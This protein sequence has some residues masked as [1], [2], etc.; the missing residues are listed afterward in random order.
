MYKKIKQTLKSVIPEAFL[1][2][3]EVILRRFHSFLYIGNKHQCI[4]CLKKTRAF[5]PIE[6][7]DLLCPSC[8]SRSRTRRLWQ[9]LNQNSHING[10]IL[11]FSPSRSIYRKLIKNKKIN[12]FSSDFEGEFLADYKFDITNIQQEDNKFDII[13]CY[14]ILEHIIEDTK[15]MNELYRVLKPNGTIYIQTPYKPGN[16]YENYSVTSPEKREIHFGQKDHVRIY[17]I[18]GLK[19]RL[20]NVGFTLVEKT[21]NKNEEDSFFGFISPETFIMATKE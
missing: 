15:A 17:S 12:Y 20:K 2:N 13:I 1:I 18:N 7:S 19:N 3:N 10:Y 9:E 16:I 21:F 4:I 14:H 8:G 6:N 5:I 11:H